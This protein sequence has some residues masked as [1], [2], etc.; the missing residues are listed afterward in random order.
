MKLPVRVTEGRRRWLALVLAPALISAAV[1][2]AVWWFLPPAHPSAAPTTGSL[3]QLGA[4]SPGLL[5]QVSGAVVHPGLYHVPPGTRGYLA[6]QMAGGLSSDADPNKL[7]NLAA[8]LKDGAVIKVPRLSSAAS[9]NAA[10]VN[11][12]TATQSQLAAVPGFTLELAQAAVI[13]RTDAGGF[14]SLTQL[15]S[16][17]GMDAASYAEAKPYLTL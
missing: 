16:V 12:N 17:L 7:P 3:G 6:V 1:L 13:Y 8:V 5:V 15:E 11:L 2:A 4:P 10:K 9:K 14:T